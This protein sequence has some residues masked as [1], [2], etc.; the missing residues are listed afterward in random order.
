MS[1]HE[2]RDKLISTMRS[3]PIP[4]KIRTEKDFETQFVIPVVLQASAYEADIRVY[5]HPWN[6]RTHCQ[7]NCHTDNGQIV[8]GCPRCWAESKKWGSVL[9]FGTHHTFDLVARDDSGKTLA[10]ELKFLSAKGGRMPNG[11]IQ[12][13]MG[14]CSIAKTKHDCVVGVCGCQGSFDPRWNRDTDA[15]RNWFEGAGVHL[16]FRTVR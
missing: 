11:E 10:V 14:Q 8:T 9:A 16:V 15:V 5:S 4:D 1:I 12:R 6:D 2:F 13:L 3:T 7:P